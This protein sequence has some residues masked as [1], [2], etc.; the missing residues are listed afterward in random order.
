M[1]VKISIKMT[2][3]WRAHTQYTHIHR[4]T[5]H[6]HTPALLFAF[7]KFANVPKKE[8]THTL[9]DVAI[10]ADRN[11]VQKYAEEK[12]KYKSLCTEIPHV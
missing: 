8:K 4:H 1:V 10:P 6:T 7:R 5:I 3:K 12:L 11:N 9:I 2:D